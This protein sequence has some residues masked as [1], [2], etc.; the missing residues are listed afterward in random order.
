MITRTLHSTI[1]FPVLLAGMGAA[2]Q[3]RSDTELA[4][5]AGSME[6]GA[7][8]ELEIAGSVST[9]EALV[10]P[11]GNG[12]I[13]EY[14]DEAK[15][16]P[17]THEVYVT[18]TARPYHADDQQFVVYSEDA[19]AWTVQPAPPFNFG[20]HGYDHAALDPTS[21]EYFWARTG[22]PGDVW[23]LDAARTSWTD[24]PDVPAAY[25]P[26]TA[27]LDWFTELGELVFVNNVYG[28][29]DG[30]E[31][32][33]FDRAAGEWRRRASG[34]LLG[35][36]E[37]FSEP[38]APHDLFVFGGGNDRPA[39]P[40]NEGHVWHSMNA[41]GEVMRLP[42]APVFLGH[43]GSGPV[44]TIDPV[45]GELLVFVAGGSYGECETSATYGF[46]FETLAWSSHA[47]HPLREGAECPTYAAATPLPEYGVIFVADFNPGA[48]H[49]WL[50]RHSD[51]V[52]EPLPI[53]DAGV[54]SGSDAGAI[55]DA[56]AIADRD[57]ALPRADAGAAEIS[58]DGCT[59]S[60]GA[61]G[62]PW[63]A[64]ALFA[65]VRVNSLRRRTRRR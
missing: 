45:T 56:G 50:Y 7:W 65:I 64:G 12:T 57:A 43:K 21:G 29:A 55:R 1:V 58:P 38:V 41:A 23:R 18:G 48:C 35:E 40:E 2:A 30:G 24:L 20:F 11:S 59:C 49:V 26:Q 42:D 36:M 53:R 37:Y 52:G 39:T 9:C 61:S 28:E 22:T 60:T 6:P 8:A 31:V 19:N 27:G 17:V 32:W 51:G 15:W 10:P 54:A 5:L 63:L 16:N 46:D 34:L 3:P 44:Q 33:S 13:L 4:R 47:G 25:T 62:A 14:T